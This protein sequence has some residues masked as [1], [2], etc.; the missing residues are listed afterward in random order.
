MLPLSNKPVYLLNDP[1]GAFHNIPL[2]LFSPVETCF[3]GSSGVTRRELRDENRG[4]IFDLNISL[5]QRE[6]KMTL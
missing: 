1:T 4:K 2:L 5:K 6:K 3:K